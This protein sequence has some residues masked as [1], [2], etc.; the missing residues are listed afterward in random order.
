MAEP[1]FKISPG[2]YVLCQ[3]EIS[4][5]LYLYQVVE[6]PKKNQEAMVNSAHPGGFGTIA[7]NDWTVIDAPNPDSKTVARAKGTHYMA[8]KASSGWNFSILILFEDDRFKGSTL[9][10][11]GFLANTGPGELAIIGGTGEFKMARGTIKYNLL[12]NLPVNQSIRE[13]DIQAF[14]TP[15]QGTVTIANATG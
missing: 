4:M 6:G 3:N 9:Q 13:L 14:Y 8:D 2:Q 15:V 12:P 5:K 1:Y 10:A 11:M 7:V